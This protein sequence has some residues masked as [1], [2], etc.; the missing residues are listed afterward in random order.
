MS[1]EVSLD[2]PQ[3]SEGDCVWSLSRGASGGIKSG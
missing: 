2:W 3:W 1:I